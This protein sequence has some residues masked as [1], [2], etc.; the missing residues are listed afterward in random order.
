MATTQELTFS[1]GTQFQTVD[2]VLI[3]NNVFENIEDFFVQ[4][5]SADSRV[6]IFEPSA[7]IQI[8]DDD[9]GMPI[10]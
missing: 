4:L 10:L 3:D 7:E 1:Q 8:L 6:T 2:V 9:N 5:T